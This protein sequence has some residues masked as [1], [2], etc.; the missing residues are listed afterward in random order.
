MHALGVSLSGS[1]RHAL[2]ARR[3][4][5]FVVGHGSR[6][7]DFYQRTWNVHDVAPLS[8]RRLSSEWRIAVVG[9]DADSCARSDAGEGDIASY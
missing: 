9:V 3:K 4:A 8:P 7:S 6:R 5:I 1:C 2:R